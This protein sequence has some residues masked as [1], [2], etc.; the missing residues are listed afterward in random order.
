MDVTERRKSVIIV[1]FKLDAIYDS[2]PLQVLSRLL[3]SVKSS[4]AHEGANPS[5]NVQKLQTENIIRQCFLST[6]LNEKLK[7]TLNIA[8]YPAKISIQGSKLLTLPA[9]GW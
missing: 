8:S 1:T 9:N 3:R 5:Q 7:I 4:C 6:V 2:V